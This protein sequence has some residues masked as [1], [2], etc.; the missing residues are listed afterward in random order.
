MRRLGN[1]LLGTLRKADFAALEPCLG[2][3]RVNRGNILHERGADVCYTYFPC[4]GS[5]VAFDVLVDG[6]R[7]VQ[8]TLIGREGAVGGIVSRGHLPAYA[9]TRVM[10]AGELFRV[11]TAEL[12]RAK[13]QSPVLTQLFARYSDCLL[14]QFMQSAACNATHTIEQRV[15]KWL[16]FALDRTGNDEVALTQEQLSNMLGVSRPHLSLVIKR[17]KSLEILETRRGALWVRNPKRLQQ[18]SCVCHDAVRNHFETVLRGVYP[19]SRK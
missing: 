12:E 15:A 11:K 16:R 14:A 4:G 5:M 3:V 9:R 8:T 6:G 17:L 10:F 13:A 19:R 2:I 1:N 18:M 7:L